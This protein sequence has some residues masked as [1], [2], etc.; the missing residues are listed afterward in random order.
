MSRL[1]TVESLVDRGTFEIDGSPYVAT[2][3]KVQ[4]RRT[5]L[6]L[7]ASALFGR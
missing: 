3:D 6:L 7:E 5:F 1:A 2:L 4:T